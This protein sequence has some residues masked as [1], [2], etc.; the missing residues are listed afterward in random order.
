MTNFNHK[1]GGKMKKFGILLLSLCITT[2]ALA[3]FW[4][5]CTNNDGTIIQ[6]NSYGN[7]KGGSCSDPND[8]SKTK[9][10]NGKSFCIS[11][12]TRNW[13]SAFTWCDSIGGHLADFSSLC[14]GSQ[15][16]LNVPCPNMKNIMSGRR[17]WTNLGSRRAGY[18]YLID[19]STGSITELH[20]DAENPA[21]KHYPTCEE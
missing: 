11:N 12:S 19:I 13:W 2:P 4:T 1:K 18:S 16:E 20:R 14:P 5:N 7:D 10:C 3:D 15:Q 9:N 21:Y 8:S 6:A 17:A